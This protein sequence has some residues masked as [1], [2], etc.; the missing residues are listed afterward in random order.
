MKTI[1]A[2]MLIPSLCFAQAVDTIN[3]D[4]GSGI[5]LPDYLY[6]RNGIF[7]KYDSDKPFTG[8]VVSP[9]FIE[10]FK[11]GKNE[12]LS[13]EWDINYGH[14][15]IEGNYKDGEKEGLWTKWYLNGQKESEVNYRD[16]EI[17]GLSTEWTWYD[18]VQ[19]A[20]ETHYRTTKGKILESISTT[21]YPSGQKESE[22]NYKN[23]KEIIRKEWGENGTMK[24]YYFR[25]V[26]WL[27][28][29][30][31]IGIVLLVVGL[32]Y[33][34]RRKI[35]DLLRSIPFIWHSLFTIPKRIIIKTLLVTIAWKIFSFFCV[36]ILA[37]LIIPKETLYLQ[38]IWMVPL[39]VFFIYIGYKFAFILTFLSAWD[40]FSF[41]LCDG[42]FRVSKEM[43]KFFHQFPMTRFYDA[44][45]DELFVLLQFMGLALLVVIYATVK[46][47]KEQKGISEGNLIS[48]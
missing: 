13:T 41:A 19:M 1:F 34:A 48:D 44:F 36:I 28:P 35:G 21:W 17:E 4:V 5:Y 29:I 40:I 42:Y 45:N 25:S 47:A 18:E 16:G 20:S 22:V 11:N 43:P 37:F 38:L 15:E 46:F 3:F 8:V 30:T 14:K 23:G 31:R 24:A 39:A 10:H 26:E 32:V 33:K 12:G 2:L 27:T 7:Y 6:E 9:H